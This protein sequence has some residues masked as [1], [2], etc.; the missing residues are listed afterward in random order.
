[1][2]DIIMP[3]Y[4]E[5][6]EVGKPFFDML[7]IQK[8]VD[9]EQI[10]V[11]LVHDGSAA[12]PA[13]YFKDFP[14]QVE[15]YTIPHK[16]VSAARNKGL[17]EAR[18]EWVTFCDFDDVYSSMYSMYYIFRG[19][20]VTDGDMIWGR[21]FVENMVDNKLVIGENDEFNYVW[22]HNKYY[23]L[24][25]LNKNKLRFN[26]DLYMSED[27]VFNIL[28]DFAIDKKRLFRLLSPMPVY[29]W[30]W[31]EDSITV[32]K[33]NQLKNMVGQF[34]K[35]EYVTKKFYDRNDPEAKLMAIRTVTDAYTW[36]TGTTISGDTTEL[37]RLV[38]KFWKKYRHEFYRMTDDDRQLVMRASV[39]E[40]RETGMLNENRPKFMDWIREMEKKYA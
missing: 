35:N 24:D 30:C 1:M 9:F 37:E 6:W 31:R 22:T 7:R 4:N 27:S 25:F 26:E 34:M 32:N 21:F 36:L 20:E 38:M 2:L 14:C 3:H 19:L 28:V 16:G 40:A 15:Q 11:L 8:W 29:I 10:R 39:K 13:E 18:A 12:F 23:R 17:E 33:K 5:P